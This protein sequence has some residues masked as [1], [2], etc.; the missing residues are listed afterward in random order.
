M[1]TAKEKFISPHEP[2]CWYYTS[3]YLVL[4]NVLSTSFLMFRFIFDEIS[5]RLSVQLKRKMYWIHVE[6]WYVSTSHFCYFLW[7]QKILFTHLSKTARSCL[8][9]DW[10][11]TSW[12]FKI[13]SRLNLNEYHLMLA[14]LRSV[15]DQRFSCFC[16]VFFKSFQDWLNSVQQCQGNFTKDAGQKMFIS[17]SWQTYEGLKTSVNY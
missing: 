15:N 12:T 5:T 6:R 1:E 3:I 9:M 7:R 2:W 8:L 11:L 10:F 16:N 13:T 4:T 14:Q 17:I